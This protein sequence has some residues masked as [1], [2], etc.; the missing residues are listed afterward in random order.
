MIEGTRI[1][2]WGAALV[3]AAATVVALPA[4]AAAEARM[5]GGIDG[6][7]LVEP[8]TGRWHLWRSDGAHVFTFGNPGDVPFLGDWDCDGVDT[9]GLFRQSD[10]FAYLRNSNDSGVADR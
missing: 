4:P 7:A 9:P 6:V 8:D 10:G 3:A 5:D 1:A 2:A